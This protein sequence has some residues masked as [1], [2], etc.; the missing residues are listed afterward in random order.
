MQTTPAGTKITAHKFTPSPSTQASTTSSKP[1]RHL[2]TE[3]AVS[4]LQSYSEY[5]TIFL[6]TVFKERL[7][8]GASSWRSTTSPPSVLFVTR[9]RTFQFAST[10]PLR[11]RSATTTRARASRLTRRRVRTTTTTNSRDRHRSGLQFNNN[12]LTP[13]APPF[14][15]IMPA[16]QPST[17][18]TIDIRPLPSRAVPQQRQRSTS[19]HCHR[20]QCHNFVNDRHPATAIARSAT[21]TSTSDTRPRLQQRRR[22]AATAVHFSFECLTFTFF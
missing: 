6:E 2:S 10:K 12:K 3:G 8:D 11:Q 13:R 18:S 15:L 7:L 22:W 9:L 4:C 16:R 21:T 14:E 17:S 5:L 1:P 20:A 19:G